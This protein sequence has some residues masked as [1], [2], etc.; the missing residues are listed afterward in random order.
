MMGQRLPPIA[1]PDPTT[2]PSLSRSSR[3]PR[4]LFA[5][6]EFSNKEK[7]KNKSQ[8]EQEHMDIMVGYLTIGAKKEL[9]KYGQIVKDPFDLGMFSSHISIF[10]SQFF[11]HLA[12]STMSGIWI[13]RRYHYESSG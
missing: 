12:F 9:D 5:T 7:R 8:K 11:I 13:L 10:V 1:P 3:F 4:S 2:R 6:L